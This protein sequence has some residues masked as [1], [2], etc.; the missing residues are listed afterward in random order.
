MEELRDITVVEMENARQQEFLNGVCQTYFFNAGEG[1]TLCRPSMS[2]GE[3]TMIQG[4]KVIDMDTH[5]GPSFDVLCEYVEPGFRPR[6]QE[7]EQYRQKGGKNIT[8]APY[9]WSRYAGQKPHEKPAI[10]PGGQTGW[11][12]QSRSNRGYHRAPP[13]PGIDEKDAHARLLDMDREGR[14][15]D[16]IFPGNWAPPLASLDI[17][18][19]RG[20]YR[21]FHRYIREYCSADPTRL[22]SIALLPGVDIAWS[23][24]E[25]K[26]MLEDKWLAAVWLMLPEGMP[27]DDPDLDPLYEVLNEYH[28]PL[29]EHSFTSEPPFWPGYRDVWDNPVMVRTASHPWRAARWL[30]YLIIGRIFDRFPHLN[31][32][33]AEVG[34]GWLP[35]WVKRLDAMIEYVASDTVP[36]LQ[37]KALEYVQMGR[38]LC[39]CE[40]FEGMELTKACYE[41]LGDNCWAFQSDYPHPEACFPDT[42]ELIIDW[43]IWKELGGE[44]LHK[45]MHGNAERI[46]RL[47]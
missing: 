46:L 17:S 32:A 38:F 28:L 31:A 47:L 6:L 8:V 16:L 9:Q 1:L 5:V 21:A 10:L 37:Y 7:M 13:R 42:A 40:H 23:I 14:D 25:L 27:I 3:G 19:Q 12:R 33:V 34:H 35:H 4:Y 2:K 26:G 24:A 30:T 44:A 36:P 22:K 20:L 39:P 18:I 29:V 15:I 45:H 43:P 11:S 41:L